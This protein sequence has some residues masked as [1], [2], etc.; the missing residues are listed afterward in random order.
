MN[1]LAVIILAAGKGKRMKS[2]IPKVLHLLSGKPILSYV[3][4]LAMELN[5]ERIV[6]VIGHGAEKV[7][8]G[9][10]D[11]IEFVEQKEQLGTGHAVMQTMNTLKNF[12]GDILILSGDVPLLKA[13]TVNKLIKVHRESDVIITVLTTK[14]NNPEGYGRIVRDETGRIVNIIEEKDASLRVKGIREINSGIYCFKKDFLFNLLKRLNRNNVQQEYYLTDA[15]DIAFKSGLKI[16]SLVVEDP[17]EVMGI[18]TQEELQK[19]EK[20]AM[21]N[22]Q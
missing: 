19:A 15:V 17:Y 21:S 2:P 1:R 8:E 3:I 4:N 5:P 9:A 6:V 18:N 20:I 10:R 16:G 14:I 12:D 7:R 11:R 22:E 13:S